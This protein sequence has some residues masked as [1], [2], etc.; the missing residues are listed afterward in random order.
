M[1]SFPSELGV[2][3][4]RIREVD[5]ADWLASVV[6]VGMMT[7]LFAGSLAFLALGTRHGADFPAEAWMVPAGA[8]IFAIS[9]V[10]ANPPAPPIASRTAGDACHY[11]AR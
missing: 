5:R 6:W 11:F 10:V 4:R 1:T 9:N 3:V 7:G 8:A 2:Y